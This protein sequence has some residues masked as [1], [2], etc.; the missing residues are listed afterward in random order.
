MY[1]ISQAPKRTEYTYELEQLQSTNTGGIGCGDL[2][3]YFVQSELKW[4][5][6]LSSRLPL[7]NE[8]SPFL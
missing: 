1:P 5:Q 2:A 4:R 6:R 8:Y 3:H 7:S